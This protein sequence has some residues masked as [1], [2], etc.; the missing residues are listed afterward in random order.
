MALTKLTQ[1][2]LAF[3][4]STGF[5][6]LP[7]GTTAERP[8]TPATGYIRFNTTNASLEGFDGTVWKDIPAAPPGLDGLAYSGGK[9]AADPAGGETITLTGTN[10]K[11]NFTVTVGGTSVPSSNLVSPTSATFVT[12]A[13]AGGDY[14]V[15]FTNANGEIAQIVNGI[16][17]SG[18]P[19]FTSP[20]AS[21]TAMGTAQQGATITSVTIAATDGA[22][23]VDNFTVTTGS[24]PSGLTLN[25]STGVL[26]GTLSLS[27]T[28]GNTDFTV[29]ATDDEGQTS[30]RQFRYAVTQAPCTIKF[31]VVGG[32]G[33]GG[34]YNAGGGGA[35][36]VR[37][38]FSNAT[39][40]ISGGGCTPEN[41]ETIPS[42]YLGTTEYAIVGGGGGPTYGTAQ[43]PQ[44]GGL[45]RLQLPSTGATI[46]SEGGGAPATRS[47]SW[48]PTIGGSGGGGSSYSTT[49]GANGTS[50]QGYKGGNGYNGIYYSGGGGG[51]AGGV[52]TNYGDGSGGPG[53]ICNILNATN[54]ATAGVGEVIGTDV[55]YG[56]GGG[57][58]GNAGGCNNPGGNGGGGNS[59]SNPNYDD[60]ENGTDGTGGGGG[61]STMSWNVQPSYGTGGSGV[62][63]MRYPSSYT[64]NITSGTQATGS[65][66][67]EG[68]EKITV[69]KAV[70]NYQF[71]FTS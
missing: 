26:S 41:I 24:L 49:T 65:P 63:I 11:A 67:T 28:V 12:P 60:A 27:A 47:G 15:V 30:T 21:P 71:N 36:G 58:S 50:C 40:P 34:S 32:G 22:E 9:T 13:K 23:Q 3:T 14:D 4:D 55:W 35:G 39:N 25:Q 38:S 43:G 33:G 54:A 45:S 46:T 69:F 20:A 57:S 61:A 48:N 31:L 66:F 18:L 1:D 52:G 8:G 29:T 51:G 62:V 37:T 68:S 19:A 70:G 56:G 16:T 53:I 59:A 10:F 42:N 6:K 2:L 44:N 7:V 5:L 64:C 17:Y